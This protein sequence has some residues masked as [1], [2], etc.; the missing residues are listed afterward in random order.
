[1]AGAVDGPGHAYSFVVLWGDH[2]TSA[3][4]SFYIHLFPNLQ[5]LFIMIYSTRCATLCLYRSSWFPVFTFWPYMWIFT[6][7]IF[8]LF[9]YS[10]YDFFTISKLYSIILDFYF[11]FLFLMDF[12][13]KNGEI[14]HIA[15]KFE[16]IPA[17][18]TKLFLIMYLY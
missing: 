1:M 11:S 14:S 8:E 2:I 16:M 7:S 15:H 6:S 3:C 5:V 18:F 10:L 4:F 12:I 13:N 17:V 9:H